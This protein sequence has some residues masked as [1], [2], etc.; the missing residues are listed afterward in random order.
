MAIVASTP[1]RL[2]LK[3]G[4]T[5]LTLSKEAG[6]AT[7]QRKILFWS[8]KPVE[9]PLSDIT[10]VL[11]DAAIDRASGVEIC[12]ATLIMRGVSAWSFPSADRKDAE[13]S[14]SAVRS[15]LGLT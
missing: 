5:T 6:T 12:S 2:V 1:E 9:A 3:C 15:F 13:A 14:A 11:V 7:L 8:P 4:S 10:D